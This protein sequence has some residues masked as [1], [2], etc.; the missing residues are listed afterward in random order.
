MK[1]TF[2]GILTGNQLKI[3]A[4]ITMT[5]D[6]IG[7][8]LFPGFKIFRIIGRLAFP[9]FAYMIAEGCSYTK[10]RKKYLGTISL[11]AFA[12]QLVYFFALHSVYQCILVTFSM[13]VLLIYAYDNAIKKDTEVAWGLSLL[14]FSAVFLL[15][16]LLPYF[17][18]GTDYKIDY[19]F[20]GVMLP[21]FIYIGKDRPQKLL[22]TTIGL[23][24]LAA[25]LSGIQWYSL[26][27]IIP[28]SLYNGKRGQAKMK[29]F[30]YI[31]YPVHLALIYAISQIIKS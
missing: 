5:V 22:L 20:W 26:A 4:A 10:N 24:L 23:I 8:Q 29:H 12:C 18:Q 9:I 30:F 2:S 31:Y 19:G 3:I 1:N 6:H 17:L 7:L 13:S 16:K 21:F 28:L 11:L 14:A 27:A 25:S 15:T